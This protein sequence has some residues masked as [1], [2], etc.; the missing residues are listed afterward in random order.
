MNLY[1]IMDCR[2]IETLRQAYERYFAAQQDLSV[3]FINT[4]DLNFVTNPSDFQYIQDRIRST[5]QEGPFQPS[6]PRLERPPSGHQSLTR[7]RPLAEFQRFH[8]DL[9]KVKGFNT[10]LYFNYLRLGEEVGEL[11]SELAQAWIE[12]ET[13]KA[14]GADST[15]ARKRALDKCRP[16]L[17]SELADCMAYLLKLANYAGIDLEAAYL[18][19]MSINQARK[20]VHLSATDVDL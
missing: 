15:Q 12:E 7:G 19:K 10:N 5:L 9:D 18:T 2:Y 13:L 20:W 8:D 17:E 1:R 11:G 3:L 16:G 4:N 6:L 14:Q